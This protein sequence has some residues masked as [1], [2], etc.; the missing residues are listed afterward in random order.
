MTLTNETSKIK[1]KTSAYG[2]D[3]YSSEKILIQAQ[4]ILQKQRVFIESP[5]L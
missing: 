4:T 2:G 5:K 3:N 1:T